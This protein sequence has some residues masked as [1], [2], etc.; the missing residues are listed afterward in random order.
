MGVTKV[1]IAKPGTSALMDAIPANG[2]VLMIV[3]RHVGFFF[4]LVAFH[5]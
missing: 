2:E 5:M 4:C 1:S 3:Q